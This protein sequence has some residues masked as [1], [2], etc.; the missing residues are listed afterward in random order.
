M[1]YRG[2]TEVQRW[3]GVWACSESLL[4]YEVDQDPGAKEEETMCSQSIQTT[5][6][7]LPITHRRAELASGLRVTSQANSRATGSMVTELTP[8]IVMITK[9]PAR[10]LRLTVHELDQ[11]RQVE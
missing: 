4:R 8:M 11:V 10:L 9:S 3:V 5:P 1:E 6:S 2:T 7:R